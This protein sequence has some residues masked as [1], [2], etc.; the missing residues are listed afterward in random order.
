MERMGSPTSGVEQSQVL[1]VDD[2]RINRSL[3]SALLE[4]A[5]FLYVKAAEDGLQALKVMETFA[6]DL[7][8]LDLMM[9][10]LDGFETCRRLRADPRFQDIPVLAQSSLARSEDRVRAFEAGVTDYVTKPIN[11]L[12]FV[13]RVRI[14]LE[15]RAMIARLKEYRRKT[16]AELALARAMQEQMLPAPQTYKRIAE[17]YGLEIDAH[18]APS[19]ELGG[20]YWDIRADSRGRLV[21]W[22]VDFSGHG[23]GSALNTFRLHTLLRAWDICDFDPA[24]FL[25]EVNQKLKPLLPPGQFATML[26]GIVDPAQKIFTYAS[27]AAPRPLTWRKGEPSV[28]QDASGIPLGILGS[29]HYETRVLPF[30]PGDELLFYSDAATE[31]QVS[32]H[33]ILDEEGFQGLVDALRNQNESGESLP[34]RLR[35]GLDSRGSLDDDLTLLHVRW[36]TSAG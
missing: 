2:N 23:V 33:E 4:R 29:V 21:L 20:D 30:S 19:S 26:A 16:E 1:V 9:P 7:V 25:E 17:K 11:A 31:L 28:Y 3:L 10:N 6:P 12:E 8:L 14:H 22:I 32:E 34:V 18:F 36:E 13:A 15:K 24:T 5:G 35:Y 27:G